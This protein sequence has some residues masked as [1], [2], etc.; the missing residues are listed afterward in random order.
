MMKR[1]KLYSIQILRLLK[2]LA[3]LLSLCSRRML[4]ILKNS[5]IGL[6]LTIL[7]RWTQTKTRLMPRYTPKS[8]IEYL[9]WMDIAWLSQIHSWNFQRQTYPAGIRKQL[10]NLQFLKTR[11]NLITSKY[12]RM[13]KAQSEVSISR[14]QKAQKYRIQMMYRTVSI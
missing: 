8:F 6:I 5:S 9:H 11:M 1:T 13:R 12:I 3:C 7:L 14:F 4:T 10:S 2:I